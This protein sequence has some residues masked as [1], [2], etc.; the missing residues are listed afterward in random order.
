MKNIWKLLGALAVLGGVIQWG[1]AAQ[2]CTR[3]DFWCYESGPSGNLSTP[4]RLD[5]SGNMTLTG[6]ASITGPIATPANIIQGTSGTG[7][8]I[9]NTAANS[10][11]SIPILVSSAVLQGSV[12]VAAA[13]TP[14]NSTYVSGV[15]ASGVVSTAVLGIADVAAASGTVVNVDYS[16]VAVA[17]TTG[18]VNVGDLL[19][20][21]GTWPGYLYTNNS[22]SAGTIVATALNAGTLAASPAL[23]RVLLHH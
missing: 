8:L 15:N 4:A 22:A 20:S 5:A 16:G 10:S 6:T 2:T 13:A 19:V 7:A 11:L 23:I 1:Q 3:T 14:T 17:L 9:A 21:T 18:A 12:I